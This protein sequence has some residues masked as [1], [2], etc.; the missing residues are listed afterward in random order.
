MS[1]CTPLRFRRF[2]HEPFKEECYRGAREGWGWLQCLNYRLYRDLA[3]LAEGIVLFSQRALR[4]Y[5]QKVQVAIDTYYIPSGSKYSLFKDF[6]AFMGAQTIRT[7]GWNMLQR[8]SVRHFIFGFRGSRNLRPLH[9]LPRSS[10]NYF[11]IQEYTFNYHR[12]PHVMYGIVLSLIMRK[13]YPLKL[14]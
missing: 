9:V 11:L 8:S 1:Q 10:E 6:G 14:S 3:Q 7:R 13:N 2:P 4:A 12:V 5:S